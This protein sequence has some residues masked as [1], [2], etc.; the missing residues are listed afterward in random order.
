MTD[1]HRG[2]RIVDN[3]EISEIYADTLI[4]TTFAGGAVCL[5]LGTTKIMP[6]RMNE[7]PK[8]GNPPS[9]YVTNRIALSPKAAAEVINALNNILGAIKTA[10][11]N[12]SA[13]TNTQ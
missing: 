6:D 11:A 10:Q 8:D 12:Q 9:V 5:S 13:Q 3:P 2:L 7:A 1:Q 4:G